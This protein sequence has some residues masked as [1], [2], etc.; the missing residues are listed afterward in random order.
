GEYRSISSSSRSPSV[1]VLSK[2]KNSTG[3]C[4]SLDMPRLPFG[5]HPRGLGERGAEFLQAL[6][7]ARALAVGRYQVIRVLEQ[8]ELAPLGGDIRQDELRV[9]RARHVVVLGLHH[10]DRARDRGQRL[11]AALDDATHLAEQAH[12]KVRVARLGRPAAVAQ[13]RLAVMRGDLGAQLLVLEA[14][15]LA[16]AEIGEVLE[17]RVV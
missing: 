8:Q 11:L 17:R 9:P 2:S 14:E 13:A 10:E 16:L 12:R 7:D 6:R 1:R 3:L 4:G 5:A 15:G